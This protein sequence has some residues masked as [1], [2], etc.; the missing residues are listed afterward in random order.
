MKKFLISTLLLSLS[1]LTQA[2]DAKP[3]KEQTIEYIINTLKGITVG[4]EKP[5]YGSAPDF[6]LKKTVEDI[7]ITECK[8]KIKMHHYFASDEKRDDY[9]SEYEINLQDVESLELVET[10]RLGGTDIKFKSKNNSELFFN[11]T[12]VKK[13]MSGYNTQNFEGKRSLA[14]IYVREE[15]KIKVRQAFNH[16]RKLCGAPE[17]IKF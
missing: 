9:T 12:I 7:T 8:L 16:L 4:G 11:K 14:Q 1:F 15:D 3:T 2:Q 5:G 17:P 6:D 13:T 10:G